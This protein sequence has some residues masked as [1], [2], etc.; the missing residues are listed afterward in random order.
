MDSPDLFL[1]AEAGTEVRASAIDCR[2]MITLLAGAPDVGGKRY[3][4]TLMTLSQAIE[5]RDW[6]DVAVRQGLES[7]AA[8]WKKQADRLGANAGPNLTD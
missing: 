3:C 5:L 4:R 6:L 2:Q 7:D 8:Y 1:A